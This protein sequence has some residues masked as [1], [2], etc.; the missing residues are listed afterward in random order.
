MFYEFLLSC[1]C[2]VNSTYKYVLRDWDSNQ[3][4]NLYLKF[5]FVLIV[6][7]VIY[8]TLI[9]ERN[10]RI[11]LSL[12]NVHG[13]ESTSFS[14]NN[15]CTMNDNS[16]RTNKD[17]VVDEK[18][19][20]IWEPLYNMR[21]APKSNIVLYYGYGLRKGCVAY[22]VEDGM[23][24]SSEIQFSSTNS[25]T[26]NRQ[27]I[28][29][30]PKKSKYSVS[31][32]VILPRTKKSSLSYLSEWSNT[33]II[34]TDCTTVTFVNNEVGV[35]R[36]YTRVKLLV[37]NIVHCIH[38][39][40]HLEIDK[41]LASFS[42]QLERFR[43]FYFPYQKKRTIVKWFDSSKKPLLFHF[44]DTSELIRNY[45]NLREIPIPFFTWNPHTDRVWYVHHDDVE[46]QKHLL[47]KSMTF[48]PRIHVT[49]NPLSSYDV[50]FYS[51]TDHIENMVSTEMLANI[52]DEAVG[53]Q[54][55][56]VFRPHRFPHTM[57]YFY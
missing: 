55:I 33:N 42:G 19:N 56:T 51:S 52:Y 53:K 31:S 45:S 27:S 40:T 18:Q 23:L 24:E 46:L 15:V 14:N 20:E 13:H 34:T 32:T 37:S 12:L 43:N 26:L 5:I 48:S 7:F 54:V 25:S 28:T 36:D 8:S 44:V 30:P 4:L 29:I 35:D 22:F 6:F 57:V 11:R 10:N 2:M 17:L 49:T 38:G 41:R 1:Y 9:E 50:S 39:I 47:E 16:S 21:C 3:Y